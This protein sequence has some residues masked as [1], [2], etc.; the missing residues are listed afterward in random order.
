MIAPVAPAASA[1]WTPLRPTPAASIDI[2][3]FTDEEV[4]P[5][6]N[7]VHGLPYALLH[8]PALANAVVAEGPNRGFIDARLWRWEKDN[9][10]HNARVMENIASLAFFY[11]ADRPWNPHRHSPALRA[12]LE[13]A[14]EFWL[15]L[16]DSHGF[17]AEYRPGERSLAATAFGTK[18]MARTLDLLLDD[19]APIDS[20]LLA[21]VVAAQG[22]T[23]RASLARDAFLRDGRTVTNQYGNLWGAALAH[24]ARQPDPALEALLRRRLAE[25]GPLFQSPAGYY[26][27]ANGPDWAYTF[28]THHTNLE[29]LWP[30]ARHLD[31]A[32]TFI[33]EEARW[34]DWLADNAVLEPD[35]SRFVL[36][37]A[38]ETRRRQGELARLD[39]PFAEV[40]PLLRAFSRTRAEAAAEAAALRAAWRNSLPDGPPLD[41]HSSTMNGYRPYMVMKEPGTVWRPDDAERAAARAALPYLARDRY[42][43]QRA[44]DRHPF[45]FTYVRRPAY[46]AAFNAGRPLSAQQRLGLG[47]LWH[48]ALGAVLQTQTASES[49]GVRGTGRHVDEASEVLATYAV[50]GRPHSPATGS[51][52]LPA[53]DLVAAYPLK[54]GGEKR[55]HFVDT[56]ISVEVRRP[57][58]FTESLPLLVPA[59]A[60]I[61]TAPGVWQWTDARGHGL[62]LTY[63]SARLTLS[64]PSTSVAGKPLRALVLQAKDRLRYQ[65][66]P[67]VGR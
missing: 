11:T 8:L 54:A 32:E 4:L 59:D 51:H 57:G 66:T 7:A 60:K 48:P 34:T 25:A 36:N 44:D 38:I 31:L 39:S 58:A 22:E 13:A 14:L 21:R 1:T 29:H 37:R 2:D 64:A 5:G 6:T 67:L 17:F 19:A 18:F 40:V 43:R 33:A 35:G 26:Y 50:A 27:E 15:G 10:P 24:L 30:R 49:G 47:L 56:S 61:T 55:I 23:L 20:D 41:M 28:D 46:Y 52:D 62:R 16:R 63:D 12:R 42:T 45:V 9:R 65:L 3:T 53:G